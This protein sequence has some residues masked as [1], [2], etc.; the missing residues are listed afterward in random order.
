MQKQYINL[1]PA[2]C[3]PN[4]FAYNTNN[5]AI[6]LIKKKNAHKSQ[7]YYLLGMLDKS[8]L[9]TLPWLKKDYNL[10]GDTSP[11]QLRWPEC[12]WATKI[13]GWKERH[14]KGQVEGISAQVYKALRGAI[15]LF[16]EVEHNATKHKV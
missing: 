5:I 12:S 1:P 7:V 8:Y 4:L 15:S 13:L 16:P 9:L 3:H 11:Q 2:P 10:L 14:P 6:H